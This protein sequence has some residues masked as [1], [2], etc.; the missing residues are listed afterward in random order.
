MLKTSKTPLGMLSINR[1]HA[2]SLRPAIASCSSIRPVYELIQRE[3]SPPA[4]AF[5]W[6]DTL[7][8]LPS[9]KHR[10]NPT[11]IKA[12]CKAVLTALDVL[13]KEGLLHAS[14]SADPLQFRLSYHVNGTL[15]SY[16]RYQTHQHL[17]FRSRWAA[18]RG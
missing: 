9:E 10:R 17:R 18:P 16:P 1:Q 12:I 5:E 4:L 11:L 13:E 8:D 14:V 15:N 6:I 7:V 3:S 2:A